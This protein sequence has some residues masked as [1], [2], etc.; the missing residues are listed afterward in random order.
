VT[1]LDLIASLINKCKEHP[2]IMFQD[3][4]VRY[5]DDDEDMGVDSAQPAIKFDGYCVYI[6]PSNIG[7][8]YE[9]FEPATWP[10]RKGYAVQ[11]NT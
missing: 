1:T 5:R 2:E 11:R 9:T 4:Y 8:E 6:E 7:S 10:D 3:V